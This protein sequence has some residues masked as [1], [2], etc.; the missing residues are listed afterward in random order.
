[1][2]DIEGSKP[3]D[4]TFKRT[5]AFDNINYKDVTHADFKTKRTTD[6]LNPTYVI[7]DDDGNKQEIGQIEGNR[8]FY[9]G[10]R[11][12]GP[13]SSSLETRDI[14]GAQP[15]TK[16]LGVFA[17]HKR[18]HF[19]KT[20]D[21][22]DIAGS[23]VGSLRKGVNTNRVSNPLNPD[24]VIP[25]YTEYKENN[26]FGL[27]GEQVLA[28]TQ[29]I[30][31]QPQKTNYRPN[32]KMPHNINRDHFKRDLNTFY[33]T[34]DRNFADIDFNKLYKA[35][36]D[37]NA[38]NKAPEISNQMH[39]DPNFR[40][41]EKKFYNM[42]QTEGS[43]FQYN[44]NKFYEDTMAPRREN[45][46]ASRFQNFNQGASFSRQPVEPIQGQ[47]FKKDQAAFYGQSYAPSD[48][49]SDRGSIFQQNAAEF[50]GLDKPV[51][52]EKIIQISSK[53][54]KDPQKQQ[55]VQKGS[56]LNEMKLREHER[57][58]ERDPKF[59]KNLRK[60]WEMKSVTTNSNAVSSNKSYAQ[61][62]GSMIRK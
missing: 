39:E 9:I 40:R 7:R 45:M 6:P 54:L 11:K 15:G 4:R 22:H 17:C 2:A 25:G 50:Y 60:F 13:Q 23:T 19:G 56:V 41:N 62:L 3:R 49:S 34:E 59:G 37:P 32:I 14:E 12:R 42:S 44:Q 48:K 46:D 18:T 35:T 53:Q 5:T 20:N 27:T 38:M 51:H 1:V 8:S 52:G 58:M 57:N 26:A 16:N 30:S 36:K 47:H 29:Q 33:G 31:K 61:Q 28:G 24:Y 43:E 21:I 10:E 55:N